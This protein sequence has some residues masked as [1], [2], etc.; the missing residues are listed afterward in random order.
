MLRHVALSERQPEEGC[1]KP[2][3]YDDRA[4]CALTFW[5]CTACMLRTMRMNSTYR[6]VTDMSVINNL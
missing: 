1:S 3:S 2:F 5:S 6:A 4:N